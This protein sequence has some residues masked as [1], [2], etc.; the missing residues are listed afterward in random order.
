MQRRLAHVEEALAVVAA[1]EAVEQRV[2]QGVGEDQLQ[3]H[4][5]DDGTDRDVDHATQDDHLVILIRMRKTRKR[6]CLYVN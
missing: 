2:E 6:N 1:T 4:V 3:R 5:L